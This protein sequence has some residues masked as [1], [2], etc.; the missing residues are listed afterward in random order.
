MREVYSFATTQNIVESA[1]YKECF[2]LLSFQSR[3]ELSAKLSKIEELLL[4]ET[5]TKKNDHKPELQEFLDKLNVYVNNLRTVAL[6]DSDEGEKIE[7]NDNKEVEFAQKMDRKKLKDV[8]YL[9][10]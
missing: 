2:K 4:V 8:G 7:T 10:N 9:N 5:R 1:E 6:D 3:D